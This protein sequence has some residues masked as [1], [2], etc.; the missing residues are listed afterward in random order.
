M[1]ILG[2]GDY[3]GSQFSVA[4][5]R[6]PY[7]PIRPGPTPSPY[8]LD[9]QPR[10][11]SPVHPPHLTISKKRVSEVEAA[12]DA[13]EGVVGGAGLNAALH[14]GHLHI[15]GAGL[16]SQLRIGLLQLERQWPPGRRLPNTLPAPMQPG[17]QQPGTLLISLARATMGS[18]HQAWGQG[19]GR[20]PTL[21]LCPALRGRQ[22]APRAG[23]PQLTLLV[24][25]VARFLPETRLLRMRRKD[26]RKDFLRD[27]TRDSGPSMARESLG[28]SVH[29]WAGRYQLGHRA[30]SWSSHCAP[31]GP[32]GQE[33]EVLCGCPATQ[34]L[35]RGGVGE[36]FKTLPVTLPIRTELPKGKGASGHPIYHM[37]A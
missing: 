23:W 3:L 11:I 4:C 36:G 8:L 10:L 33:L 29:L 5:G 31:V 14:W 17:A 1:G 13:R 26:W 18:G 25:L 19:R 21:L 15:V 32:M 27:F 12:D 2:A 35:G 9:G 6:L 16:L 24:A 28:C 34:Q 7:P 22:A 20:C 37:R 30:D